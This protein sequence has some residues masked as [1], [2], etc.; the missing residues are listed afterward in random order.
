M[1]LRVLLFCLAFRSLWLLLPQTYF[2]P[3]EF[4]QAL[5]P[6]HH[7][8]FGNGYLSWEWQ[9]LPLQG[10]QSWWMNVIGGGRMR[11]WIWPS[12]FVGIYRLLQITKLD[13]TF[14]LVGTGDRNLQNRADIDRHG[15]QD[16]QA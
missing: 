14:L 6:A 4:Y 15:C 12:V 3:D 5:E 8:V 13:N 7:H 9:D 2:Q 1:A 10:D 11:G 16:F